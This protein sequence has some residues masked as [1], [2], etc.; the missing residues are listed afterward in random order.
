MPAS[1]AM[2]IDTPSVVS[3]GAQLGLA[4]VAQR[5]IERVAKRHAGTSAVSHDRAVEH[6]DGAVRVLRGERRGRA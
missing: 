5:E 6:R 1:D 3:D 4:E 2:P